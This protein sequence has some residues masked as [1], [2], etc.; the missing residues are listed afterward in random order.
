M[1]E[2][3]NNVKESGYDQKAFLQVRLHELLFK[4]DLL[5]LESAQV[6]LKYQNSFQKA[7]YKNLSSVFATIYSKLNEEEKE[8]GKEER[9]KI[10]GIFNNNPITTRGLDY[11]GRACNYGSEQALDLISESLFDFRFLL[12]EFMDKHGFNPSKET[13]GKAIAKQ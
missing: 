1:T 4:I 8:S 9:E 10:K 12:E 11:C 13:A 5:N 6:P 2:E 7:I 3:N